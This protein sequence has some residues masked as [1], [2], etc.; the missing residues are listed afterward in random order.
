MWKNLI[1]SWIINWSAL[2]GMTMRISSSNTEFIEY[3]IEGRDQEIDGTRRAMT[4]S[5][6]IIGK[7]EGFK[8]LGSFVQRNGGNLKVVKHRYKCGLMK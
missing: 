8:Y 7:V 6:D 3:D 2:E 4:I 1:K 5:G